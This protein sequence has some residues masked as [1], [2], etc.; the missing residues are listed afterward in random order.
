MV[1]KDLGETVGTLE[2]RA[3]RESLVTRAQPGC[4]EHVDSRDPRESLVL[5]G[6][7][8][9]R[10]PQERM[11]PLVSEETKEMLALWVPGASRVNGGLR[12][13]VVWMERRE[14]RE[15]QVPWV[16]R[17]WQD[18]K[19]TWGSQVSRASQGPLGRRA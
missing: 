2:R 6:S 9:T 12:E 18:A 16:A 1:T 5:L 13:P 8:V 11:E 10:D 14:I 3:P 4:W 19:E 7:L 17:G 15:K